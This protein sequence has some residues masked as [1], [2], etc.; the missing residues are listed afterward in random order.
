MAQFSHIHHLNLGPALKTVP[1]L[2]NPLIIPLLWRK[3]ETQTLH[4]F[5]LLDVSYLSLA[6]VSLQ[7]TKVLYIYICVC[8]Y[9]YIYIYI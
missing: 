4:P 7:V 1:T 5:T 8:V 9:I 6:F 3:E 2:P